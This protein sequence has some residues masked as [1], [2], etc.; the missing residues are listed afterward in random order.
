MNDFEFLRFITIGQY[1]PTGSII[2]RL[3]PRAR[4]IVG[5]LW[6]IALTVAPHLTGIGVAAMA[7]L[8]ALIVARIPLDYALKGLLPPLPFILLLALLQVFFGPRNEGTMLW[9]W[10]LIHVSQTSLLNGL[11]LTTRFAALI[12][13]ISLG[14]FCISTTQ[15]VQGLES[16]LSPLTQLGLPVHDF[17]LIIQVALRF[18]PLLAQEAE[19]I[20][21][22]QAARGAEW[23]TRG[24]S[25]LR[26]ARQAIP[27]LLPLFLTALHRAENL[28]LAME[29]RGY[30]GSMAQGARQRTSMYPLQF[31]V[32]DGFAVLVGTGIA[33]V[34][35]IV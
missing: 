20:A 19:Y 15:I 18:L 10:G 2:H 13:C 3:D 35:V 9:E 25:P 16:L 21:K 27:L 30:A 17:V 6:L 12:L 14:S 33:V 31:K 8:I 28:A 24:G 7:L 32:Q 26:R 4:L 29:A 1:L 23:G 22:S 11:L 34:M 5:G